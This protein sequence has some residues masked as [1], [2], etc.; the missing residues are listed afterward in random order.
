MKDH[1]CVQKLVSRE[2][3]EAASHAEPDSTQKQVRTFEYKKGVL[4]ELF[5]NG[6]NRE[7]RLLRENAAIVAK[8]HDDAGHFSIE[9]T[10]SLVANE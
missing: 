7:V 1:L 8:L 3:P 4:R 6:S 9:R 5:S 2:M 10:T